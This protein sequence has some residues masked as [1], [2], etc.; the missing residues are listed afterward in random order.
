MVSNTTLISRLRTI[1]ARGVS[2]AQVALNWLLR[3]SGITSVI[4]GARN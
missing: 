3:Q 4:I 2:V 1:L